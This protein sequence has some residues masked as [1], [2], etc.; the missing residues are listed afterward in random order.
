MYVWPTFKKVELNSLMM[1]I[2]NP[3]FRGNKQKEKQLKGLV[4]YSNRKHATCCTTKTAVSGLKQLHESR[5]M[6]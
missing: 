1:I 2:D 3:H 4:S 6:N 5:F